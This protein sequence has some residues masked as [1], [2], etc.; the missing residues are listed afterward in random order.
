MFGKFKTW[1][2]VM[3]M[4]AVGLMLSAQASALDIVTKDGA[5]GDI[6]FDPSALTGPV[7]DAVLLTVSAVATIVL[8]IIGVKWI[9]RLC[10]SAG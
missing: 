1:L 6:T 2:K 8:V 4:F 5:T 7:V 3:S 10:K 9:Y